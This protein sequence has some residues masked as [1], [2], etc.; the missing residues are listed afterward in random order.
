MSEDR[1]A[2]EKLRAQLKQ[3]GYSSKAIREILE[4]YR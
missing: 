1:Q 3:R 2:V 4:W